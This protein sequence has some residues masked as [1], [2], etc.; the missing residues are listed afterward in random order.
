MLSS[1]LFLQRTEETFMKY[2]DYW[3]I[4]AGAWLGGFGVTRCVKLEK[5]GALRD[6]ASGYAVIADTARVPCVPKIYCD[7]TSENWRTRSKK[8]PSSDPEPV[9]RGE[10]SNQTPSLQVSPAPTRF[11]NAPHL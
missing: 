9:F 7:L 2:S 5:T 11:V 1:N 10:N 6:R 8:Q 4:L 3:Q